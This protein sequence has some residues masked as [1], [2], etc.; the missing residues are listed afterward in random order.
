MVSVFAL[1]LLCAL[2]TPAQAPTGTIAGVV[3]DPA[4]APVA[5][6]RVRLT[7]RDSGLNRSVNPSD[8]GNY[9]VAALPSGV[10]QVTAEAAGFSPLERTA[11]VEAG[12]TTTVNLV[13]Q[14]GEVREQVRVEDA[15]PLLRYDQHQVGGLISRNQIENLPLN[16]R[17]FLEL[18]KLEPGVTTPARFSGNRTMV[19][20]LGSPAA[21]NGSRTRVTVDGGSIMAVFQGGSAMQFSQEVVREFQLTSANFD[22][23]TGATASGA[24]NI[25]TRSGGNEFHGGA[26][27]FYR[28]HNLAAYPALSRDPTNPDPFFQRD[29]F[30]FNLGGPLRKD[31]LFFFV[32]WERNDQRGVASVQPRTPEF[33]HFGQIA[34]SPN[35]GTLLSARLDSRVTQ[36]NYFYLR[37]SHDGSRG[38]GPSTSS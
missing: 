10:Y 6:A 3:T 26:F 17:D 8:E 20:I 24:I 21:N 28:D 34:P 25:V 15:T 5:G 23:S 4:G 18:A 31:R 7:N 1:W 29:Q 12:T 16:G 11:T 35:R 27:Y 19:P 30:G 13:L 2:L 37:Y 22:L 38:F 33:A 14:I 9:S 32:N 36:N